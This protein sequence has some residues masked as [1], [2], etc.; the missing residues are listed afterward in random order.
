MVLVANLVDFDFYYK[1][2]S[3]SYRSTGYYY[4]DELLKLNSLPKMHLSFHIFYFCNWDQVSNYWVFQVHIDSWWQVVKYLV[5]WLVHL[6]WHLEHLCKSLYRGWLAWMLSICQNTNVKIL[7]SIGQKGW[8]LITLKR[9]TCKIDFLVDSLRC[10]SCRLLL[11]QLYR[12]LYYIQSSNHQ[13][14][15]I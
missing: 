8:D 11:H 9:T 10:S 6:Y 13:I 1:W 15:K 7:I 3:I 4:L 12:F 14:N 2:K 5:R